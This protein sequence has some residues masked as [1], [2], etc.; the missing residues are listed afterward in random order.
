MENRKLRIMWII[1]NVFCHLVLIG[2]SVWVVAN[3]E[4]LQEINSLS[5]YVIF[6]ILLFFVSV[7]G[8]YQIWTW[9]KN[10]KM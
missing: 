5:I 10:G 6:I 2:L 7:F 3:S 1:P 4:G 8:S 9:I